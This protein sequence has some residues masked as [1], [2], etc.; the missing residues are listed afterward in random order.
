MRRVFS[1]FAGLVKQN[2]FDFDFSLNQLS[3]VDVHIE[4][5]LSYMHTSTT[6]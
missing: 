4:R 5:A 6:S 2:D 1:V 3:S